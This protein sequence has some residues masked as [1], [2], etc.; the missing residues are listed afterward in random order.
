MPILPIDLQIIMMKMDDLSREQNSQQA[1][2]EITQMIKGK[3]LSE[4]TNLDSNRVNQVKPH[5]DGNNK[6]EDKQKKKSER[7]KKEQKKNYKTIEKKR[8]KSVKDFQEP[9][10]GVHIDVKR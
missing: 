3:E 1:G 5:P 8:E 2:I 10:K 4:L 6:I 7:E 9:D